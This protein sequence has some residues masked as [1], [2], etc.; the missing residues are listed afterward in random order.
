MFKVLF[1]FVI[2][3][4]LGLLAILPFLLTTTGYHVSWVVDVV[5]KVIFGFVILVVLKLLASLPFF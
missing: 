1:G 5:F 4:V 2:L 3:V